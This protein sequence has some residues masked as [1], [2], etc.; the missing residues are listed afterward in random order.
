MASKSK[1]NE[2]LA[3][4]RANATID[5]ENMKSFL[6]E[7]YYMDRASYLDAMFHRDNMLKK[8]KP[9]SDESY[10]YY[11]QDRARRYEIVL[12][13]SLEIFEYCMENDADYMLN[14]YHVS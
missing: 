12:S 8:I 9:I 6:G 13:K 3:R 14:M 4:E 1:I 5:V 11:N 2:D 10:N 7:Q